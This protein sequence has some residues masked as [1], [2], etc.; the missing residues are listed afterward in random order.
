MVGHVYTH[1]L[2]QTH[3][4]TDRQAHTHS[5]DEEI[6]DTDAQKE[7]F[8]DFFV[9]EVFLSS[10]VLTCVCGTSIIGKSNESVLRYM[11]IAL[12][13]IYLHKY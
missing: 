5:V 10:L 4:H 9:G 11:H 2:R 6:V 1:L 13:H 3:T 12:L 7:R 8:T